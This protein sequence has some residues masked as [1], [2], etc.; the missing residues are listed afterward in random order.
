MDHGHEIH[1]LDGGILHSDFAKKTKNAEGC[2]FYGCMERS[3]L[4]TSS[5]HISALSSIYADIHKLLTKNRIG[6]QK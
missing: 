5:A 2:T 6:G 3:G 4:E 1:Y